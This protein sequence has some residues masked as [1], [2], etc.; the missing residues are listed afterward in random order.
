MSLS[1]GW[2][3]NEMKLK[4]LFLKNFRNYSELEIDFNEK[5]NIIIGNNAQGKTNI[6]EAIY[7]LAITKSFLAVNDKTTI[8][9]NEIYSSIKGNVVNDS[10]SLKTLGVVI[11]TSL[12]KLKINDKEIKKH[13]EYIGNLRVIIFSPDNIRLIKDSPVNRRRFLNIEISQLYLKYINILNEF[14]VILKQ[15]NEYLKIMKNGNCNEEYFKILNSKYAELA[16]YIFKYRNDFIAKINKYIGE[17][18]FQISGYNGLYIKYISSVEVN[19]INIIQ[20]KML[21]M[22]DSVRNREVIYGCSLIGPQ[23]D[24]FIFVL[25]NNDLLLYGSQGQQ[26]M[27]ILALKLAE[28]SVFKEVC[29][30]NP[31]LL[32]DDLF[33]ELDVDKRNKII[34]YLNGDVQ[35]FVTTTDLSN[36]IFS[37]ADSLNVYKISDG[38]II[39]ES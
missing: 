10:G 21:E 15:R 29:F 2:I 8:K 24:D 28:I 35:T 18:F 11:N 12:K 1:K 37:N 38:K 14:N 20:D 4:K 22:L 27:A 30:D 6:L 25:N 34:N 7:Y 33:S 3:K 31:I 26:K 32:L 36:I 16:S 9:K 5:L 13:C 17:I 23:R 19:E 39:N